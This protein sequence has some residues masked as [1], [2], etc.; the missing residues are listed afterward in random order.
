MSASASAFTLAISALR[1]SCADLALPTVLERFGLVEAQRLCKD[2]A[3]RQWLGRHV[4]HP[5]LS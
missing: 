4:V 5:P 1:R 3:R 2:L